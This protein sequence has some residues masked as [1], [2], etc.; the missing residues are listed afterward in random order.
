MSGTFCE[1]KKLSVP[2]L[3]HTLQSG[4]TLETDAWVHV[5]HTA[6]KLEANV[7]L[8]RAFWQRCPFSTLV[9]CYRIAMGFVPPSE[10]LLKLLVGIAPDIFGIGPLRDEMY[11]AHPAIRLDDDAQWDNAYCDRFSLW[12]HWLLSVLCSVLEKV[13][14]DRGE[15]VQSMLDEMQA[16]TIAR[17]AAATVRTLQN[18]RRIVERTRQGH[19][20]SDPALR[21]RVSHLL[22][23][24][25]KSLAIMDPTA[26]SAMSKDFFVQLLFVSELLMRSIPVEDVDIDYPTKFLLKLAGSDTLVKSKVLRTLVCDLLG[27]LPPAVTSPPNLG[28]SALYYL[29]RAAVDL[30]PLP[31]L[32]IIRFIDVVF[33]LDMAL[34]LHIWEFDFYLYERAAHRLIEQ[35]CTDKSSLTSKVGWLVVLTML[36]RVS[37]MR[38][39]DNI[40][41]SIFWRLTTA[42]KDMDLSHIH[43]IRPHLTALLRQRG[44]RS[45][46]VNLW[47]MCEVDE[48][49]SWRLVFGDACRNIVM[50]K[51]TYPTDSLT[52]QPVSKLYY[53][54]K[55]KDES[56]GVGIETLLHHIALNGWFDPFTKCNVTWE[57]MVTI[58]PSLIRSP[59]IAV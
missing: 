42:M 52:F 7:E 1:I 27:A 56:K 49:V 46:I 22:S 24:I 12:S 8:L 31:K 57:E 59:Y 21:R 33:D 55:D 32:F 47:S 9:H 50:R 15:T 6:L 30:N 45:V 34:Y 44:N 17:D 26:F 25:W 3:I 28:K 4:T 51:D 54:S 35:I 10:Q 11:L 29:C 18:V 36:R 20:S 58:N 39:A 37:E 38:P 14:A 19:L 40:I 16:I 2:E 48:I 13:E 53:F 23:K 41:E 43:E 5:F